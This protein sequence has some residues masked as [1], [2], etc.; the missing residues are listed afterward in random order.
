MHR[1][2]FFGELALIYSSPRSASVRV[3][4]PCIFWCLSQHLFLKIQRDM[5]KHNFRVA[6]PFVNK[7][8]LFSFLSAKQKDAISYNMNTLKYDAGDSIFKAGDDAV[9]F[10]VIIA[11]TVEI[12]IPGKPPI[13]FKSGDS[14]G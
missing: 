1:G 12:H 11:G 3:T 6:K 13:L 10:I 14:F 4:A 2:D 9:S 8:P 7:L 5:V